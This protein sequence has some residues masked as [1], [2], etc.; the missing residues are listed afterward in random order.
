MVDLFSNLLGGV[1]LLNRIVTTGILITAFALIIYIL[2]YNRRSRIAR[3]FAAVLACLIGAYL[4]DLLAQI[5]A[6]PPHVWLRLQWIGIAFIPAAALSLSDTLLSA[7]GDVSPTRRIAA[8]AGYVAG[9]LV[10]LLVAF[11]S[12]VATPNV[13][14][15]DLQQ[16]TPGPLF[17]PFTLYYFGSLAWATYN[18]IEARRRSLTA[19]SRRRMTYFALAFP[20][21]ALG[22]FPYLLPVGWPAGL[23]VII[24]WAAI[25]LVNMGVGAAITFM[26]YTVAY[27]GASA[28][29]RVIKRRL[30][31]YLIRGPLLAA[32]VITALTLSVRIEKWFGLPGEIV[33]LV[34]AA[35]IILMTQL[36][37]VTLQP[38]LDR[39]IAGDDAA[40]VKRLQQFSERLMTVSDLTQFLENI[41]AALCDLLRARTAFIMQIL[42]A[43][44]NEPILV[45]IGNVDLGQLTAVDA[46]RSALSRVNGKPMSNGDQRP[47]FV[48]D[49]QRDKP[50]TYE[51]EHDFIEWN[52][53]WLIPLC[54]RES[55]GGESQPL[56]DHQTDAP[57]G[58]LPV[59]G[60]IGLLARTPDLTDEERQGV[61][62]LVNQAARA[63]EDAIKQQRAFEA[64]ERIIPEA[65]DMQ[66]RMAETRN[67]AAPTVADFELT[68]AGYDDFTHLVRDALSHYWGGPKLTNSPLMSLRVVA[69]AM[70]AN[71]GNATRA[72][73]SVLND[74]IERLKPD[75]VRSMTATEWLLYNILEMK[76]IQGQRVRD[77]ARKLVMSESDLYRKQRAAFEEVARIVME[78]EREARERELKSRPSS[79]ALD[80]ISAD[81]PAGVRS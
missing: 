44:R 21:P 5:A 29:D 45:T 12:W 2:L 17:F 70:E 74:A 7:T 58:A 46:V 67:P 52:G 65:E 35:T 25:L 19:T 77:V 56:S 32:L 18:V 75:G 61:A 31:K 38:T 34:A 72:L 6:P 37:I 76:I 66:R 9:F 51:L 39:L 41:L 49:V 42:P 8:R 47:M 54:A 62:L 79:S 3:A 68:P 43:G 28:P 10:F 59:L 13:L 20:A 55:P 14:E 16:L 69:E 71:N 15:S 33:G 73:R 4:G 40:E 53:Y 60:V 63:L 78:M 30:I 26:G 64:L 36:F 80:T 24:P 22:T 1:T 11:T 50:G 27:F 23:P 81:Q 57:A 48:A